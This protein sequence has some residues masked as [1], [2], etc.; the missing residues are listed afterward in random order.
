[1]IRIIRRPAYPGELRH[2]V[3]W[4]AVLTVGAACAFL[5]FRTGWRL[6]D[7]IFMK[8]TGLP[9]L[10]CGGTRSARCLV[11]LDP[12]QAFLFHPAF[13]L[14]VIGLVLW[15][16]YSA[17]VWLARDPM[18]IRLSA[19]DAGRRLLRRALFLALALHWAWQAYYLRGA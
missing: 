8:W 10:G 16:A 15:T 7:C 14:T 18:R 12:G 2:E 4:P 13:V 17:Y 11:A 5:W 3:V 19:D 9:C 6:P 1:M